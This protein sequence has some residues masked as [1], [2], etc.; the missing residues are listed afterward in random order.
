MGSFGEGVT[1]LVE[2]G[3]I[4]LR[5]GDAASFTVEAKTEDIA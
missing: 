5:H 1:E 2:P 3:A 4:T